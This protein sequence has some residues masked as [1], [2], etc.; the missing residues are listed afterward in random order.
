MP[1]QQCFY[2]AGTAATG[3]IN[4]GYPV[5]KTGVEK[6]GQIKNSCVLQ[7]GSYTGCQKQKDAEA[8]KKIISQRGH[9]PFEIV[10]LSNYHNI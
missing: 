8:V 7:D 6:T 9:L 5:K 10:F 4:A 3:T 2:S 1:L